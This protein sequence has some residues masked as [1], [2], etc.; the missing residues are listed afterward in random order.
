MREQ[1]YFLGFDIGTGSVGYAVT[2]LFYNLIKIN[3]KYAWGSVLFDTSNGAEERRTNRTN[4]RRYGREK[5]R[6]ALL[7][8]LFEEEICKI[9]RGFFIRLQES[10]FVFEDKKDENGNKPELPYGLFI[11]KNFTDVDYYREFPTIF[12]LRKKLIEGDKDYDVRLVFLAIAH[13]LK[14]RGHF[15]SNIS[16]GEKKDNIYE[17]LNELFE[18]FNNTVLG[19]SD[20]IFYTSEQLKGI[21]E[22]LN[23]NSL[24]KSRKKEAIIKLF[25]KPDSRIKE[26]ISLITGGKISCDKLFGVKAFTESE[27]NK[28][29]FEKTDFEDN[30]NK[31]AQLLGQYFDVI[32]LAKSLYDQVALN[33][34]LCEGSCGYISYAKVMDY[35]KHKSDLH[36][37]KMLV[38]EHC[39][40]SED[41]RKKLYDRTFKMP[42]KNNYSKYI[43]SFSV[44]GKK[45]PI[46]KKCSQEE[47]YK[48]LKD[49]VLVK[50]EDCEEKTYILNQIELQKFLP[51]LRTKDNSV[52]PYQLNKIELNKILSNAENYLPFLKT[53]DSSGFTVSEKIIML[54][55]FRVPYYVGPLNPASKNAWV[56]RNS[57]E[58]I[59]PWNFENVVDTEK[60]A[61]EFIRK[62][63]SKCTYLKKEDVLPKGSI[64]Y[65]K[66]RVLNEI[67]NLKIKSEPIDIALKQEIYHQLFEKNSKVTVKKLLNYLKREKGITLKPEDI[68][69]IDGEFKTSLNS[70][71]AFK[72]NFT[73]TDL[74]DIQKEDIIKDITL[75][76]AEPKMLKAR[77]EKK[78]PG[79]ESQFK[80]LLKSLKCKE[81][82]RLSEKLLNGIAVDVPGLGQVGTVI[83][84]MWNTNKN[85]MQLIT[86]DN[87][88]YAK[89]IEKENGFER[90]EKIDYS[91]ID[92]LYVSP[93]VKRALWKSVQILE[94]ITKAMGHAPKR[95]FV[96]MTREH[97]ASVRSV[98]R[99]DN[100]LELYKSIKKD[101]ALKDKE[102]IEKLNKRLT[103]YDNDRLRNDKLYLYFTQLGRCAYTGEKIDFDNF[104]LYDIDHIYPRSQTEDN[105]LDNRVLVY[106]PENIRKKDIYPITPEIQSN[107]SDMWK[108]WKDKKLISA[109]KYN[110]LVRTTGLTNEELTVFINRQIVETSQSTKVFTNLLKEILPQETEIVYSKASNVN[111]FRQ[112]YEIIKVREMND[113][114]HAKDAYLNIVVGNAYHIKFTKD[115]RK[116]FLEKGTYRTYNLVKLFDYDIKLGKEIAWNTQNSES[117][118]IVKNVMNNN[119]VLVTRQLCEKSGKLFDVNPVKKKEKLLSLKSGFGNERLEN[120]EKYGGYNGIGIAYFVIF[121]G[122]NK[123]GKTIISFWGM[124]IYLKKKL[125][126]DETELKKKIS[127]KSGLEEV[128]IINKKVMINT[129]FVVNGFKMRLASISADN[130]IFNNAN[131]LILDETNQKILKEVIKYNRD[132]IKKNDATVN[133]KNLTEKDLI[134][135]YDT[136]KDKLKNSIYIKGEDFSN[137]FLR[138][139][140][141]MVNGE[142]KFL[143]LSDEDKAEVIYQLLKL[144]KCNP[145]MPNLLK[146]GGTATMGRIKKTMNITQIKTLSIVHQSVT[147]IYEKVERII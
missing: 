87:S 126:A 141:I 57:S 122:K 135:L 28:I 84:Q 78:Y 144:F 21:E 132:L 97:G 22:N 67:N 139:L 92:E 43:G 129:L 9:D 15:L 108:I 86:A 147:G 90:K 77:L 19:N 37:L 10:K 106:R 44:N 89:I 93:S 137:K 12:H 114:H 70:Y 145:E 104:E 52:I 24:S 14:H 38:M 138:V 39:S 94:E 27:Y 111:R 53:K 35:E 105:S 71:H 42:D 63:T 110:R 96:E 140:E 25:D 82:G 54:L 40:G 5:E 36:K 62:L 142:E 26:L 91:V 61:E 136:F 133:H 79:Y 128:T 98:K 127:E 2:D 48:F 112:K 80:A 30:E 60:S 121:K 45:Q 68:T 75:F 66:Y 99:R 59:T 143:H 103:D 107:M 85:L 11:D 102:E 17:C 8:E 76:G 58:K 20:E 109:E 31:Y 83:Y 119:K 46:D 29:C 116:Y 1:E 134:L 100:L 74:S 23:N 56:V 32:S 69:G 49:D 88:E 146:I 16:D 130:I 47:F 6:L 101:K 64:L 115:I 124:P 113:L 41:D 125:E 123:K 55:T 95:V 131:Q 117:I 18:S 81:W 33:G 13:I 7:R 3:R 34:I 118:K 65:E 51:K 73:G 72:A 50:I 4:R 120:T